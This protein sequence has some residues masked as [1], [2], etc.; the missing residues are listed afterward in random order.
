MVKVKVLVAQSCSTLWN[1]MDCSSPGS[2]VHGILQA[3]TLEW[4]AMPF[5]RLSCWPRNWT[6]VSCI[7]RQLLY[8][9]ITREVSRSTLLIAWRLTISVLQAS[10]SVNQHEMLVTQSCL[11]LCNPRDCSSPGS[12]VHGILQ[13][14]TQEWIIIPL[15]RG[16][17][18]TKDW[19]GGFLHCRQILYHL[20]HQGST[21]N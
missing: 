19:T 9:W 13:A 6:W 3:R 17:Y 2:S 5:S 12:S 21:R 10:Y 11:I 7:G 16:S 18:Q 14:R 1:P 15:S 8:H 20:S 4:V